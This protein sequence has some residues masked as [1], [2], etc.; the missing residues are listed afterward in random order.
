MGRLLRLDTRT[1]YTLEYAWAL[2]IVQIA[3]AS[4][5]CTLEVV[6]DSGQYLDSI[7]LDRFS[8]RS[9]FETRRM[10]F[11]PIREAG[12]LWFNLN[13]KDFGS[14]NSMQAWVDNISLSSTYLSC[15][16]DITAD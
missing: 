11:T 16:N 10:T 1:E 7:Q 13:C 4:G 9:S 5:P 14:G 8:A 2:P 15:P 6:Y 3:G 12:Y